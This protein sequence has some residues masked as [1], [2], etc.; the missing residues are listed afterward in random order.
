MNLFVV[1]SVTVAILLLFVGYWI[2]RHTKESSRIGTTWRERRKVEDLWV[3][4]SD[5]LK[6]LEK[7][8]PDIQAKYLQGDPSVGLYKDWEER[9]KW[10]N[11]QPAF[12]EVVIMWYYPNLA[13]IKAVSDG[14]SVYLNWTDKD[15]IQFYESFPGQD[16]KYA[17]KSMLVRR[18]M[19]K[20]DN[21]RPD[22]PRSVELL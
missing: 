11:S 16:E 15:A 4:R 3:N 6:S 10:L 14:L 17:I 7:L 19:I 8:P 1:V 18:L 5:Y 21:N 12:D 22:Q 20:K 9:V 2:F 13:K